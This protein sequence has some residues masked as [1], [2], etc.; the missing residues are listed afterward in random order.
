M[1]VYIHFGNCCVTADE[2]EGD[3][4]ICG[5]I[6]TGLSWVLII[7][8]LPFSLCVCFKVDQFASLDYQSNAVQRSCN[9]SP[10]L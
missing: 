10:A 9:I 4:G 1:V 8:T 6:L 5:T 3:S 7:F 2:S